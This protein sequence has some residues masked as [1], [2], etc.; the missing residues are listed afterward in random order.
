MCTGFYYSDRESGQRVY[1]GGKDKQ[2]TVLSLC[3][4]ECC[5]LFV[6]SRDNI[7]GTY[8]ELQGWFSLWLF[9][10]CSDQSRYRLHQC[11]DKWENLLCRSGLLSGHSLAPRWFSLWLASLRLGQDSLWQSRSTQGCLPLWVVE[12]LV[13]PGWRSPLGD[14]MDNH[15]QLAKS[16][17]SIKQGYVTG[18]I[19]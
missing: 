9:P 13:G 7:L 5:A 3:M 1:F 4:F 17:I 15:K 11:A 8:R 6:G 16:V 18:F 19:D 14:L 12:T 2:Y 10:G